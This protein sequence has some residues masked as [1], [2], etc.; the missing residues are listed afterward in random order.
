MMNQQTDTTSVSE[1]RGR[2]VIDNSGDKV[3]TVVDVYADDDTRQ[4]EWLAVSTG[5]FGT[6]ISF[7][8]LEGAALQPEGNLLVAYDKSTIKDAPRM[9]ADG[10]LAEDEEQALYSHYGRQYDS[11]RN[12]GRTDID[13]SSG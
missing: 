12:G 10:H 1:L 6:K 7:V 11:G 3:G 5:L 8:P 9:E 4:P 13:Q 2:T